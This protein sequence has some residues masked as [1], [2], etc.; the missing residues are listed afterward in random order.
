MKNK[1]LENTL[2]NLNKNKKR[3]ENRTQITTTI[4]SDLLS[5]YKDMMQ[6][7]QKPMNVGFDCM[8]NLLTNNEEFLKNFLNELK[9]V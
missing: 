5:D 9:E 7:L 1:K 8:L 3:C 6:V 4:D 2:N